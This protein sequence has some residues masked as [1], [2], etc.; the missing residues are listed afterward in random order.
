VPDPYVQ[1]I[2]SICDDVLP[3]MVRIYESRRMEGVLDYR[4]FISLI[5]RKVE[6]AN[7]ALAH[8][9]P[10]TQPAY[11]AKI[12]ASYAASIDRL[13]QEMEEDLRATARSLGE[14]VKELRCLYAISSLLNREDLPLEKIL[15]GVAGILPSGMQVPE[16]CGARIRMGGGEWASPGFPDTP[17]SLSGEVMGEHGPIGSVEVCYASDISGGGRSLF[18]DEERQ[19]MGEVSTRLGEAWQRRR[20]GETRSRLAS[21]VECADEAIIGKD[22]DG[23]ILSWNQGAER[24]YGYP[25]RE[26]I[27]KPITILLAPGFPDDIPSILGKLRD[28]DRLDHYETRRMCRGGRVITVSIS[29]SPILDEGGRITGISTIARDISREK[30]AEAALLEQVHL[31]RELLDRIPVP[32]FY[33]DAE[34]KYLGCNLAFEDLSGLSREKIIGRQVTDLWPPGMADH[35][36]S[37]D[38][39]ILATGMGHQDEVVFPV[40]GGGSRSFIFTRAPFYRADGSIRGIVGTMTEIAALRRAEEALRH[41]EE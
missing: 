32:V 16:G 25:A 36:S 26:V 14:R 3:N 19:L 37:I 6:Q 27:G 1:L 23:T 35:Y 38:R 8:L 39:E 18:L 33:K 22:L 12:N 21:I 31:V 17:W 11:R 28:G 5:E 24:I 20:A 41:R 15:Q 4:H 7:K 10:G 30:E 13:L 34:G 2:D 9:D 29:V 40:Q